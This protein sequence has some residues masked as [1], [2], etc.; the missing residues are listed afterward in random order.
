[1]ARACEGLDVRVPTL[2]EVRG[3]AGEFQ[4]RLKSTVRYV[5]PDGSPDGESPLLGVA[6]LPLACDFQRLAGESLLERQRRVGA[7][8]LNCAT[9][10]AMT[11][12]R[13]TCRHMSMQW[14]VDCVEA[15][16][17]RRRLDYTPYGDEKELPKHVHRARKDADGL[18]SDMAADRFLPKELGDKL[19]EL[20]DAMKPGQVRHV[21]LATFDHLLGF[22][23]RV[24]ERHYGGRLRRDYVIRFYDPNR[25]VMHVRLV[26]GKPTELAGSGLDC[27][28]GE[29]D[30]AA[31]VKA[32]KY[33]PWFEFHHDYPA[34]PGGAPAA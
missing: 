30:A 7:I 12:E 14:L 25:S 6:Y 26:V 21:P 17:A 20:L 34:A 13:V 32:G 19:A 28:M 1:M 11:G 18:R 9:K 24:K 15:F 29:A 4:A 2:V 31:L 33:W 5:R 8:N 22:Q 27:F 23:L 16:V 10:D 3:I